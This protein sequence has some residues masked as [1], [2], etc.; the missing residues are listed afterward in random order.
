[1]GG[2]FSNITPNYNTAPMGNMIH[3]AK[4]CFTNS[5]QEH[6]CSQ[7][8]WLSIYNSY[9]TTV[10]KEGRFWGE[11]MLLIFYSIILTILLMA[12]KHC[13]LHY[14]NFKDFKTKQGE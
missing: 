12:V 14:A 5:L 4:F 9:K 7:E 13:V 2:S 1:M 10:S 3:I 11:A 8:C 6:D